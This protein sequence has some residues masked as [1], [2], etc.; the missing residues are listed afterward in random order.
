MRPRPAGGTPPA[1]P[2]A[3]QDAVWTGTGA[4]A[5]PG[6]PPAPA[7]PSN[8]S[9]EQGQAWGRGHSCPPLA[10]PHCVGFP[11]RGRPQC[12]RPDSD[13]SRSR[14][15]EPSVPSADTKRTGCKARCTCPTSPGCRSSCGHHTQRPGWEENNPSANASSSTLHK[16]QARRSL[17]KPGQARSDRRSHTLGLLSFPI[18]VWG[19]PCGQRAQ[20]GLCP[21]RSRVIAPSGTAERLRGQNVGS[22]PTSTGGA[23]ER[24]LAPLRPFPDL[25]V[26]PGFPPW[27]GARTFFRF[28]SWVNSCS[29]HPCSGLPGWQRGPVS[30]PQMPDSP[31]QRGTG[32]EEA[33]ARPWSPHAAL[34][35]T[36]PGQTLG[37]CR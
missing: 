21:Q 27:R 16:L 10:A 2:G 25:R 3:G 29:A 13:S 20:Q 18:H 17:C 37:V 7:L 15:L 33:G 1:H 34:Q 23:V 14:H 28:S 8:P 35:E 22:D 30:L 12:P 31:G 26:S 4:P 5:G 9:Q 6:A 32:R 19:L 24:P 11:E 36:A